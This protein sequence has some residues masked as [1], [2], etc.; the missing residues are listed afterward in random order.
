MREPTTW[1]LEGNVFI[2]YMTHKYLLGS[3]DTLLARLQGRI[4]SEGFGAEFLSRQNPNGHWGRYYYQPKWTST[5]Y[6]LLDLKNLCAPDTLKSCRDM[7]VRMFDECMDKDGGMNLSKYEHPSDV[8]V[9]GMILNYA[10]YFCKDEPRIA[11]LAEHLLSAQKVDGGFTWDRGSEKGEPHTTI[12]VMEGLGQYCVSGVR[13]GRE[14][15]AAAKARA[16]EFLLSQGLFFDGADKRFQ[17]L[18]YPYRYRYDLLR[19]L[20]CFVAYKTRYDVRMRPALDWLRN[21]RKKDGF[22]YLENR[23]KRNV[24]FLMEEIGKP[25]RL[26]T[27]KALIIL[28]YFYPPRETQRTGH[29]D[30]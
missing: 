2:Q 28:K 11:R 20:E 30:N 5:H 19:A 8:A 24:H 7:I 6:T 29:T 1:L 18:S 9:D 21:K 4:A 12:C 26:I 22:W 3:D 25:S 13:A 27:L 15:V 17:K 23:H 16:V 10:S 14:S